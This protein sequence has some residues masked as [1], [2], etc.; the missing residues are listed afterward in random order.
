MNIRLINRKVNNFGCKLCVS[1]E[2]KC[3]YMCFESCAYLFWR[4]GFGRLIYVLSRLATFSP[5]FLSSEFAHL[6]NGC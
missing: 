3:V 1:V 5:L 2:E 6:F 4:V